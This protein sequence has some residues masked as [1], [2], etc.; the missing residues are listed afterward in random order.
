MPSENE[1][2]N[3]DMVYVDGVPVPQEML[4]Q[5]EAINAYETLYNRF[6]Q[7]EDNNYI[8]PDDYAGEYRR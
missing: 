4:L 3:N 7:D 6:E 2:L 5:Q 1:N 8:L